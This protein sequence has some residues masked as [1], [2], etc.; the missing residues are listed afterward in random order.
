LQTL[1]DASL[2]NVPDG[3][4]ETGGIAAGEAAAAA[5]LT[6]RLGDGRGGPFV[7]VPGT[8]RGEW[9]L[10]PPQGKTGIVAQDPAPWVRVRAAVPRA[11]RGDAAFR[12]S[13]RR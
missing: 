2:A 6:D 4:S 10:G 13:E 3:A 8:D 12:G 11:E 5:M 1:Y 7:F 9:R